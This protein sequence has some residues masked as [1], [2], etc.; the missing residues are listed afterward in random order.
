MTSAFSCQLAHRGII[1]I[2]GEDRR[3]FLQGLISNDINLCVP[4]KAIYAALL[5]PQ[6]KFL[7]DMFVIDNGDHFLADC[8]SARAD[9]LLKRLGT[10]K[11]RAK[12]M[13]ENATQEFD[14]WAGWNNKI[15]IGDK[16][17]GVP[18]PL[19]GRLGGGAISNPNIALDGTPPPLTPPARGGES[20][21]ADGTI[22]SLSFT[23]PRLP[24]LGARMIVQKG[25][26]PEN[27]RRADL[28]AYDKHRLA[29]GVPDGSRDMIVE[30]ST[31]LEGNFDLLNGISWSKG[32]YMGQEL[33]ARMHYRALV[34]KRMFPVKISGAAP[35]FGS[36]IRLN[37]EDIGDMRSSCSDIGLALLN[38]EKAQMAMQ[39]DMVLVCDTTKLR[40]AIGR[41]GHNKNGL[42][43]P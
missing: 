15:N 24:A 11:L 14:V 42:E 20:D 35:A 19:R 33:T 22:D 30:K 9:D 32:C 12:V 2:G 43:Y 16:D 4:G 41:G 40:V 18:P 29:L 17:G 26:A 1:R 13:L 31:L 37:D 5:T 3:A 28:T 23:D 7:H 8:E 25:E 21:R 27:Y 38:V 6:G 39:E 36:I 10:Y 34:K